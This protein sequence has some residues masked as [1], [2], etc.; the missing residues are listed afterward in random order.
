MRW[1]Y[2][3]ILL[4]LV[5]GCVATGPGKVARVVRTT[6]IG[7][8]S[9]LLIDGQAN[10]HLVHA[11][12]LF[13]RVEGKDESVKLVSIEQQGERL[14]IRA[15]APDVDIYVSADDIRDVRFGAPQ[16]QV[17]SGRECS[18]SVSGT[19]KAQLDS[20]VADTVNINIDD[21]GRVSVGEL[22]AAHIVNHLDAYG[23]IKAINYSYLSE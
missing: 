6:P 8:V 12:T 4:L 15:A 10:L 22:K 13:V 16:S 11:A 5:S 9:Q 1:T 20:I 18:V 3:G 14:V 21:Q 23:S 7:Q 2:A 17:V 19:G